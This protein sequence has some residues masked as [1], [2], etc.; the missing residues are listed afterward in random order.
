MT[1]RACSSLIVGLE[2]QCV[3]P[4]AGRVGWLC[5]PWHVSHPAEALLGSVQRVI[6]SSRAGE[7]LEEADR[8]LMDAK[9]ARGCIRTSAS[10]WKKS[11][12][13]KGRERP[14]T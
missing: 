6:E 14:D 5:S 4:G 13:V 8:S 7:H 11:I 3:I 12:C 2:Q 10:L 9:D 1:C